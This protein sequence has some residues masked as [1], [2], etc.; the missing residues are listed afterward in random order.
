MR[1]SN[2]RSSCPRLGSFLGQL[3]GGQLRG[4]VVV[5]EGKILADVAEEVFRQIAS[6]I[7]L[8]ATNQSGRNFVPIAHFKTRIEV[9]RRI[10]SCRDDRG[11]KCDPGGK[12]LGL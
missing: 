2:A 7:G 8:R 12:R 5:F 6:G 3:P 1:E 10:S 4:R 11:G 9:A